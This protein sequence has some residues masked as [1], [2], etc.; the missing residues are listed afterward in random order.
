MPMTFTNAATSELRDRIR[1]KLTLA[2][3][4]FLLGNSTDP[5]VNELLSKLDDH[6]IAGKR[7]LLA[8]LQLD[9]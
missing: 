1:Q 9:V 3:Q 4:G 5:F 2:H 8:K 7:L 6:N